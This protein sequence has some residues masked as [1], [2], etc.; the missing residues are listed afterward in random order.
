MEEISLRSIRTRIPEIA[1]LEGK[2]F[3]PDWKRFRRAPLPAPVIT[4]NGEGTVLETTPAARQM[5]E[6]GREDVIDPCFFAHVHG[7]NLYQVMRDV[8]DMVCYGKKRASW[9]ARLR[10]GRGRWR[11]FKA[12]AQVSARDGESVIEIGLREV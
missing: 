11:W 10:T 12:N 6:Y 7:K 4:I 2:K 8:A 5:L 9:L 3:E 1:P